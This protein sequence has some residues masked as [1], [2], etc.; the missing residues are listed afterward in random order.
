LKGET[1][2]L[3]IMKKLG[4][5]SDSSL[6]VGM[7]KVGIKASKVYGV[8]MPHLRKIAE[9]IGKDHALA[10]DCGVQESGKPG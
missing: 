5:L 1:R 8:T 9:Q 10:W 3:K 6:V 2:Y 4:A 7:A